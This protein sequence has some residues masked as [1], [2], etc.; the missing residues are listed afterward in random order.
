[1][2]FLRIT[3]VLALCAT[4]FAITQADYEPQVR[5]QVIIRHLESHIHNV[6]KKNKMLIGDRRRELI[7]K[8]A[9][10]SGQ[11]R[12]SYIMSQLLDVVEMYVA[13]ELTVEERAAEMENSVTPIEP[14]VLGVTDVRLN[15]DIDSIR[16][17]SGAMG[18]IPLE[19]GITNYES[20]PFGIKGGAVLHPERQF[21]DNTTNYKVRL[22][23]EHEQYNE[24][25]LSIFVLTLQVNA[26][27]TTYYPI[28][29]P[30]GET[31]SL[32]YHNAQN[33]EF[34]TLRCWLEGDEEIIQPQTANNGFMFDLELLPTE[35]TDQYLI[36]LE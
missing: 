2:K 5:D 30:Y 4:N 9:A 26:D 29:I 33:Q 25:I 31:T 15:E 21:Y 14:F 1:M 18:S 6:G 35:T 36:H 20:L 28:E 22:L 13:D 10:S 19:L 12:V 24:Q 11:P 7:S 3:V 17:T 23:C 8:I 27:E 32:L 34:N 16:A